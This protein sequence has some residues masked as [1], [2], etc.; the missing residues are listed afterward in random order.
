MF[1]RDRV[2]RN[3]LNIVF[4]VVVKVVV[5]LIVVVIVV[6]LEYSTFKHKCFTETECGV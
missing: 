3:V 1:H 6:V 4:V 5:I 2:F